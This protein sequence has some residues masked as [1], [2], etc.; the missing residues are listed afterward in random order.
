MCEFR[1]II[2]HKRERER[3]RDTDR[4]RE[5]EKETQIQTDRDREKERERERE[6]EIEIE[7]E[8]ERETDRHTDNFFRCVLVTELHLFSLIFKCFTNLSTDIQK[9]NLI[10]RDGWTLS[11]G[12]PYKALY[13]KKTV[14]TNGFFN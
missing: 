3:E 14:N 4:Q 10:D 2:T 12:Q 7:I 1:A 8:R 5:R 6:I 9:D 11:I 13:S